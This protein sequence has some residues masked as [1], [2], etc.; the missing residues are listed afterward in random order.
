APSAVDRV[1]ACLEEALVSTWRRRPVAA[2]TIAAIGVTLT[3]PVAA[4]LALSWLSGALDQLESSDRVRVFLAPG[5]ATGQVAALEAAL[6]R[7]PEVV[8]VAE[9]S[10]E[11]AR[12]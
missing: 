4:A 3:F 10:R 9:V 12:E 5:A 1:V 6:R 2:A 8:D 7:R 11:Q